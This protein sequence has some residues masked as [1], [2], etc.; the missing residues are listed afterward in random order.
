MTLVAAG[1]R[2]VDV[3]ELAVAAQLG[4]DGLVDLGVGGRRRRQLD[5]QA[6][7]AGDGDLGTHLAGGVEPDRARPPRRR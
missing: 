3:G 6:V 4:L 2:A 1:G 5:A 7:V